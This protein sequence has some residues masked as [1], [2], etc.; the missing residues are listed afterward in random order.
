MKY[1]AEIDGLRA[2]AVLPVIL[3]HAGVTSISG[4]FIGVDVFFVISGFLITTILAQELEAGTYSILTF[5]ER[6][7]RRILPALF[8]VMIACMPFAWLW[9]FPQ[10]LR[11][12]G[13]S[14]V[15]TVMFGSNILFWKEAGYFS[16]GVELKPLLHTWSLAI[17][18]QYYILFPII[19]ALCWKFGRRA[20]F[21]VIL[22]IAVVSLLL[23][24]ILAATNPDF[25][26]Y[27]LPTR[28]WELMCGG[29][30]AFWLLWRKP[31]P[32]QV[33]ALIGALCIIVPIAV[34]KET[35]LHPSLWTMIPVTGTTLLLVF[36]RDGTY[37]AR[38]LSVRPL[39]GIGLISY[40]AYLWHQPL[41]AFARLSRMTEP[42]LTMMLCL[43][44]LSLFLAA[45]TWKY[46]EE[47]F[48]RINGAAARML[49]GRKEL[50]GCSAAAI[51]AS[52]AVGATLHLADGAPWRMSQT[53][54]HYLNTDSMKNPL[55][56]LCHQT[57]DS[58]DKLVIPPTSECTSVL[59]IAGP[60]AILIG[61]SHADAFAHPVRVGL[62][63]KGWQMTQL[64]VSGCEPLPGVRKG[65]KNCA[66][67]NS[68]I[69]DYLELEKFDLIIVGMR[70][71]VLWGTPFDN[72]EGG[73]EP[74]NPSIEQTVFDAET[75]G[76]PE[77][78]NQPE[79]ATAAIQRGMVDLLKLGAH[80]IVVHAIPE[81]GW[82]VPVIAAQRVFF[83]G[84]QT[85]EITTARSAY[86]ERAAQSNAA[87]DA[88]IHPKIHH[89]RPADLLCDDL[90]CVNVRNEIIYYYDDDHLSLDGGE[91]IGEAVLEHLAA[92]EREIGVMVR[93][94]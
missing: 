52:A 18:E 67:I 87:L 92:V 1:R 30:G 62:E 50:L 88:V 89:V 24:Q 10:Q 94:Q 80:V 38:A 14:I 41:F 58:S 28:A 37:V 4:G 7:A 11:D 36:A 51:V 84:E 68:A 48:R 45:L 66:E 90:R 3:F 46:V 85:P 13:Q 26:F 86:E 16:V 23:A 43:A 82:N 21:A 9:M 29:L 65:P 63:E 5:Y 93:N 44:A 17:E 91:L 59:G 54:L 27:M 60:R 39:V 20:L 78:S 8:T 42:S 75:L 61:D 2:I 49:P 15:A 81:A 69:L 6:R 56:R 79:L 34:F 33:L 12:F 73:H 74:S 76:L 70:S 32:S 19:L 57:V 25:A 64:T 77:T 47:P 55:Q 22:S 72:G 71:Q 31:A 35:T 83:L 53:V 40:S